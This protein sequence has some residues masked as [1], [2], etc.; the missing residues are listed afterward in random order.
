MKN[1]PIGTEP[2]LVEIYYEQLTP[3]RTLTVN[4]DFDGAKAEYVTF[5]GRPY[6]DTSL[7]IHI[8]NYLEI[9][10]LIE[11]NSVLSNEPDQPNVLKTIRY[12][13]TSGIDLII[14]IHGAGSQTLICLHEGMLDHNAYGFSLDTWSA[15]GEKISDTLSAQFGA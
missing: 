13:L 14:E 15:I 7:T 9:R 11:D 8:E 5:H 2:T 4:L 3:T 12:R 1:I 6:V 10:T